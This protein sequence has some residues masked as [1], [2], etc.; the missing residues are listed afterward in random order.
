M[1]IIG[2]QKYFM[3]A[4]DQTTTVPNE[5][6]VI[7]YEALVVEEIEEL[8]DALE[9]SDMNNRLKET[10]D[11]MVVLIGYGLSQGWDMEGAWLEVWRSNM[12]KID[13]V[14]GKAA[15]RDDGKILKHEG[16]TTPDM[17][18]YL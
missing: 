17:S 11:L 2:D 12:S 14:T 5:N 16:Y 3:E 6:Q 10:I 9:S 4:C 8:L 13:P 1:S 7:L 18:K 15:R